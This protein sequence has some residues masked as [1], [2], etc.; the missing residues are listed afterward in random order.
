MPL[1]MERT[2]E[3][4]HTQRKKDNARV[5]R[6]SVLGPVH[7]SRSM[8]TSPAVASDSVRPSPPVNESG[9]E[10]LDVSQRMGA[11]SRRFSARRLG[12]VRALWPAGPAGAALRLLP[13]PPVAGHRL[14][15]VIPLGLHPAGAAGTL[16]FRADPTGSCCGHLP[17]GAMAMQQ[18]ACTL[19]RGSIMWP[20]GWAEHH[21]RAR[22]ADLALVRALLAMPLQAVVRR[23]SSQRGREAYTTDSF[24]S[25]ATGED[26]V[27]TRACRSFGAL[28]AR[29]GGSGAPWRSARFGR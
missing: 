24:L 15:A 3:S 14:W 25:A 22:L 5:D 28:G 13:P 9:A 17:R 18:R 16:F 6:P 21:V 4:I 2:I 19:D 27:C 29:F 26:F 12:Q 23:E 10:R 8:N 11:S 1:S 7:R 20:Y